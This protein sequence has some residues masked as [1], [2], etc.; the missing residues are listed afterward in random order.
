MFHV[1]LKGTTSVEVGTRVVSEI[2]SSSVGRARI[3]VDSAETEWITEHSNLHMLKL[4]CKHNNYFG[5]L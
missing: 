5:L 3:G 4:M 1:F 2:V